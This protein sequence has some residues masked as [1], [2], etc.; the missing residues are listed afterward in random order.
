MFFSDITNIH[1]ER[2]NKCEK[3]KTIKIASPKKKATLNLYDFSALKF[4]WIYLK[5][6]EVKI[7]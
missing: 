7:M 6:D 1:N 3:T 2:T 4:E 5:E